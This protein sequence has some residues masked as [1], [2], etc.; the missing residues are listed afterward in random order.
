MLVGDGGPF[1]KHG[2][3]GLVGDDRSPTV[4]AVGPGVGDSLLDLDHFF[5]GPVFVV[6]QPGRCE[7]SDV[8]GHNETRGEEVVCCAFDGRGGHEADVI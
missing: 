6:T 2:V 1:G 8:E 4:M 7:R 3:E 5:G